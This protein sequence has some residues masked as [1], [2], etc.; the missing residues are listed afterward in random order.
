MEANKETVTIKSLS[1]F[2]GLVA[3][4]CALVF[5]ITGLMKDI[6][7][8]ELTLERTKQSGIDSDQNHKLEANSKE[9]KQNTRRI[10]K[11]EDLIYTGTV[12]K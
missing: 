4:G 2:I 8:D 11:I 3:F 6:I 10:E 1:F 9:T 5:S 12:V 7:R